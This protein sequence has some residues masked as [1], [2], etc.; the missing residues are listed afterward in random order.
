[1]RR[2]AWSCLGKMVGR[3]GQG[4]ADRVLVGKAIWCLDGLG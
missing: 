1:M 3:N 4:G 2:W